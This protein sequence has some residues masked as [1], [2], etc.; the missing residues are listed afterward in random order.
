MAIFHSY[1]SLPEGTTCPLKAQ[2]AKQISRQFFFMQRDTHS[3]KVD[4]GRS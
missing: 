2:G 3:C 4:E 1:V